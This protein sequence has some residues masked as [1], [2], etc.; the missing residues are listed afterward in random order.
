M[1]SHSHGGHAVG[2]VVVAEEVSLHGVDVVA[3]LEVEAQVGV[4]VGGGDGAADVGLGGGAVGDHAEWCLAQRLLAQDGVGGHVGR[5]EALGGRDGGQTG[6]FVHEALIV[7]VDEYEAVFGGQVT[8]EFGL[9]V[10][11]P[12]EAPE[13]LDVGDADIGDE[14]AVGVG[15][16]AQ[17]LDFAGVVGAHL[18]DGY[19]AL[20]RHAKQGQRHPE[21]VVVV[22]CGGGGAVAPS[23]DGVDELFGGRLAVG[24]GDANH[25]DGHVSAVQ[26]GQV[27][28]G[29]QH[30]VDHDAAVVD[31]VAWVADDAHGGSLAEGFGREGVAV[32]VFA[33]EGEE[34]TSGRDV[35]RVGGDG[36]GL[37]IGEI[38]AVEHLGN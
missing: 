25:G 22:A 14:A 13:A 15:D 21:V 20:R 17:G 18:H 30:V 35:A 8:V 4:A 12:F 1:Q 36:V 5:Q 19:L 11:H 10:Y 23:Q 24:A 28:Q 9:G 7:G 38:E 29:L 32:E 26:Y 16:A 34:E 3:D 31:A 6:G 37:Q 33:A 27:L 2:E